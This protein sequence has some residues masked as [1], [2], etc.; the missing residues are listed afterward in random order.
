MASAA[1]VEDKVSVEGVGQERA[2]F[3]HTKKHFAMLAIDGLV[4]QLKLNRDCGGYSSH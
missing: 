1:D 2:G 4:P 3:L